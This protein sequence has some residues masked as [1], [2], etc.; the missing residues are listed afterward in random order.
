[1]RRRTIWLLAGA[2][3]CACGGAADHSREFEQLMAEGKVDEILAKAQ[4]Y[5]DAGEESAALYYACGWAQLERDA[6]PDAKTAFAECMLLDESYAPRIALLW[7]DAAVADAADTTR[8]Y[9]R[10]ERRMLQ[11]YLHDR[12]VDLKPYEDNVANL[13][14][15]EERRFGD[16][17]ELYRKLRRDTT[18]NFNKRKEWE[19]R[20]GR[21]YQLTGQI[22]SALT[23]FDGYFEKF[24]KDGG[25]DNYSA[26]FWMQ[27]HREQAQEALARNDLDAALRWIQA[28]PREDYHM[29]TQQELRLLSGQI[30]EARGEHQLALADYQAIVDEGERFGS[31]V[32]QSAKERIDAIHAMGIR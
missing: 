25:Y 31:E 30:R 26:F 14:F 2:I 17:L 29:K 5:V 8:W 18:M 1:M 10:G 27:V 28:A 6:D 13:L 3:L 20:F 16:A 19:F 23:I 12:S 15:K 21:C 11:A 7:R 24:P 4:S 9:R 32:L 22:D